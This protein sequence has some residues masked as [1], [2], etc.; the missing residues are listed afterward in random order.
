VLVLGLA[1]LGSRVAS[2]APPAADPKLAREHALPKAATLSAPLCDR[3]TVGVGP[4]AGWSF[5]D[6]QL[7]TEIDAQLGYSCV[8]WLRLEPRVGLGLGGNWASVRF[9]GRARLTL[10]LGAHDEY[11]LTAFVGYAGLRTFPLGRMATFC[12]RVD[13]NECWD[14]VTGT[15]IGV[16]F[17]Y[18][19]FAFNAAIGLGPLP[20]VVLT[21][22]YSYPAKPAVQRLR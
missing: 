8:R 7:I 21:L 18:W 2:A 10:F 16:G 19:D 11:G 4:A 17:E 13:L 22:G 14:T 5:G 6:D 3:Y 15:E 9:G 20:D 12:N 1:S